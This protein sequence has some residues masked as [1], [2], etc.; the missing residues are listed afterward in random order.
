M[1]ASGTCP[2]CHGKALFHS[3]CIMDRGDGNE[4]LCL[5][6][7]RSDSIEAREI[8]QFEVYV[9]KHCGL[10]ELYVLDPTELGGP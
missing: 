7:H 1:K 9:C 8:G 6:I 4:A 5:A 3:A 2:K 10:S